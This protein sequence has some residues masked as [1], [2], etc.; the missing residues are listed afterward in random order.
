MMATLSPSNALGGCAPLTA[1]TGIQDMSHFDTIAVPGATKTA[2]F[3]EICKVQQ[4]IG[5]ISRGR[6]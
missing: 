6:L 4:K 5:E 1:M 3:K 2:T